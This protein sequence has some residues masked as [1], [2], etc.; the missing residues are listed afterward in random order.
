MT[1]LPSLADLL[2]EYTFFPPKSED[3][4]RMLIE[5]GSKLEPM[6]SALKVDQTRVKGC[7]SDVWLYPPPTLGAGGKLHFLADS[8]SAFTKG[9]VTLVLASIQDRPASEVA[10]TDIE[11]MLKPFGLEREFTSKRTQGIPNMIEKIRDTAR[12][13]AV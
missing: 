1:A 11:G 4:Y 7:S 5:L 2:E 13:L 10:E 8:T 3:R 12:R 9:V 6:P